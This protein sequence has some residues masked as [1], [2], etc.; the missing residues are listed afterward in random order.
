[1][2]GTENGIIVD[3]GCLVIGFVL[4]SITNKVITHAQIR[5]SDDNGDIKNAILGGAFFD[6][7][8]PGTYT[9]TATAHGY[10]KKIEEDFNPK[11]LGYEYN[12]KMISQCPSIQRIGR[13]L[14]S[15]IDRE[16]GCTSFQYLTKSDKRK[17]V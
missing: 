2:D 4:D 14:A 7:I 10:K 15:K 5:I 1:M 9:I 13:E 11:G 6:M 3:P 17:E 12:I 16:K 8:E